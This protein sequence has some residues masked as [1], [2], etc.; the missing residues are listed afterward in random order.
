MAGADKGK[1]ARKEW[2]RQHA[3]L[4][5]IADKVPDGLHE[6][7]EYD[8]IKGLALV[9]TADGD[10]TTTAKWKRSAHFSLGLLYTEDELVRLQDLSDFSTGTPE[11]AQAKCIQ[12]A[13]RGRLQEHQQSMSAALVKL[14]PRP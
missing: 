2:D 8:S 12:E 13:A 7:L 1:D 10:R 14:G 9:A 6:P 3:E 4:L 5:R 11:A